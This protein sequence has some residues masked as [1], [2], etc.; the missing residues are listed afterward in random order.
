[1]APPK[2]NLRGIRSPIPK[3]YLLGRISSGTGPVELM[4]LQRSLR[5]FG[6]AASRGKDA[7]P[8]NEIFVGNSAGQA[9]AVPVSGDV[10]IADTGAVTLVNTA[11]TPA[12]YTDATVTV[13]S[14]GRI[15]AASN[16]AGGSPPAHPGFTSGRYY[17]PAG[18]VANPAINGLNLNIIYTVPFYVPT[19]TV[20][21][22]IAFQS[23]AG[24]VNTELGIYN[25]SGGAPST[26]LQDLGSHAVSS[27]L[28]QLTGQTITLA[29]GW[30]WLA[31]AVSANLSSV[32]CLGGPSD[33]SI[34]GLS[35]PTATGQWPTMN[36]TYS[37]GALPS[38]FV[39]NAYSAT[40]PRLC[41][42]L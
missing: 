29:A 16:G 24:S 38:P 36:W 31:I 33:S 40:G 34:L 32:Y 5:Q 41:L 35:A 1:M 10:T 7:L 42:K 14:K 21:T 13:D 11:V 22:E 20:F 17:G 23:T 26:L 25:N 30:Y 4:D 18:D 12:A 2:I 9:T 19:A 28:N 37:A 39:I 6:L 8:H 27:G 3:G 15:T